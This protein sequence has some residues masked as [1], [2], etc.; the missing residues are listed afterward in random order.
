MQPT[1]SG[2]LV[3]VIEK[4]LSVRSKVRHQSVQPS[5]KTHA[6]GREVAGSEA[7][8]E[9]L[10]LIMRQGRK[11]SRMRNLEIARSKQ[12]QSGAD[13]RESEQRKLDSLQVQFASIRQQYASQFGHNGVRKD[14]L[15]T[16]S[17]VLHLPPGD[18]VENS[19]TPYNESSSRDDTKLRMPMLPQG[20]V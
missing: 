11:G 9:R 4:G 6:A 19:A 1:Y 2:R 13:K 7:L 8:N 5:A 10:D 3:E 15:I 18:N 14:S 20:R 17:S 16:D 12:L